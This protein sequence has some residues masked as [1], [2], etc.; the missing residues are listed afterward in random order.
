MAVVMR[1]ITLFVIVVMMIV[2]VVIVGVIIMVVIAV[3]VIV[4][5]CRFLFL[6]VDDGVET[7]DEDANAAEK[8]ELVEVGGEV[9][10][11]STRMVKVD[12]KPSP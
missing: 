8:D 5:A 7:Q 11:D 9:F 2:V 12:Q 3:V 10:F 6:W 1:V 4:S